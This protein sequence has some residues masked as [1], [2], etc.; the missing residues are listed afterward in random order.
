MTVHLRGVWGE[1]AAGGADPDLVGLVQ[2]G[3]GE[4]GLL[5]VRDPLLLRVHHHVGRHGEGVAPHGV[6]PE[7]PL[8]EG[9]G[10]EH[11]G[12]GVDEGGAG[13]DGRALQGAGGKH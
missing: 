11:G 1:G 9:G 7:G 5:R 8:V 2:D 3:R 10:G 13:T 4:G 6:Q 12:R